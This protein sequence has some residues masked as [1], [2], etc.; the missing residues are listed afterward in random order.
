MKE[1]SLCWLVGMVY[2]SS[3][4]KVHGLPRFYS[5]ILAYVCEALS[6]FHSNLATYEM[7]NTS[8]TTSP[9]VP[10]LPG[11][12]GHLV[13]QHSLPAVLAAG[14]VTC[15]DAVSPKSLVHFYVVRILLK[16]DNTVIRLKL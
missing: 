1:G 2:S 8:W 5:L 6:N 4:A 10:I 3:L 13:R 14:P 15:T 7:N 12:S 16:M 11:S 9:I